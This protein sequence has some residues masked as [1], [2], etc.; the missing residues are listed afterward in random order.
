MGMSQKS[1]I[2]GKEDK[3]AKW[4]KNLTPLDKRMLF[5]FLGILTLILFFNLTIETV[6]SY[7]SDISLQQCNQERINDVRYYLGLQEDNNILA[8]IYAFQF[9][10]TLLIG[11]MA[12]GWIFHGVGFKVIGR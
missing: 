3:I 9:P 5:S 6:R 1:K 10:F 11:A 12:L 2:F 8:F 7:D 4:Y